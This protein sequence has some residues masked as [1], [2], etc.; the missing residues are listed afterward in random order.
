MFV[1]FFQGVVAYRDSMGGKVMEC[2]RTTKSRIITIVLS[3]SLVL[4]PVLTYALSPVERCESGKL[5]EAGKYCSCRMSSL[6]KGMKKGIPADYS[7]CYSKLATK[8]NKLEVKGAGQCPTNGDYLDVEAEISAETDLLATALSGAGVPVCGNGVVDGSE[9]CD[10]TDLGGADCTTFGFST[11]T[12]VCDTSCLYNVSSCATPP[13]SCGNGMAE[14]LEE[15]DGSDLRA[16]TCA[17]LGYTGGGGLTC[18]AGCS[19]DTSSCSCSV[20][21]GSLTASG[22]TTSYGPGSDGSVRA[23]ATLA[24]VDNGDGTI[25]DLNTGLMWEKKDDSGGIHDTDNT[26]SWGMPVAPYSM[27]GTMV[28]AFLDVLNDVA[29]GGSSCFAGYC[30]WRIP[31]VRELESIV[32]Y[33]TRDPSVDSVFNTGCSPGCTVTACSCTSPLSYWTSSTEVGSP[34]FAWIVYFARGYPGFSAKYDPIYRVRAV[35][36]GL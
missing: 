19:Y 6:S 30:D 1:A 20:C 35:R 11:G 22:Q 26:Y 23:G 15:C 2:N 33:G 18:T 31:N 25:S 32:D 28:T 14:G 7:K 12:L 21:A 29:G 9:Q 27:N 13:G 5:K 24:Y 16:A 17:S 10:G 34:I 8:W 4:T 36:G 3:L